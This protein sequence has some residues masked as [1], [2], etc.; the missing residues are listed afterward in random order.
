[1]SIQNKNT[2]AHQRLFTLLTAAPASL[3]A[4]SYFM[5]TQLGTNKTTSDSE[6]HMDWFPK[7]VDV[8]QTW[9]EKSSPLLLTTRT[10]FL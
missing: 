4:V 1:M 6:H 2:Q 3:V 7:V 9:A 5:T 8:E 10:C